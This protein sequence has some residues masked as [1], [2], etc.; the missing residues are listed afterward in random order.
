MI[1]IEGEKERGVGGRKAKPVMY[2]HTTYNEKA[3]VIGIVIHNTFP[4]KFVID[5][6]DYEKVKT[7]HWYA[8]TN[9]KYIGTSIV[10]EGKKKVLYLHNLIMNKLTFEGKGST[11]T[12]DHIN[13]NGLDNR[14]ENLRILTQSQQNLNQS[15]KQRKCI[16]PEDCGLTPE[17]LPKHIWY[18]KPNGLHGDRFGIDLKTENVKWKTSSSKLLPL[19]EK[20]KQAK[21]KLEEFYITYP[22]LRPIISDDTDYYYIIN[23]E[24]SYG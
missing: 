1:R 24:R 7:R 21:E 23:F 10:I 15:Q 12:V 20:L 2:A 18:I 13:R 6:D 11:E 4:L 19:S 14:K 9:G 5:E 8:V 22:Y 3:Y 16:L 17:D